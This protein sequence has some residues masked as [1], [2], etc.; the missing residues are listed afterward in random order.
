MTTREIA[1]LLYGA[2]AIQL[3]DVDGGEEGF[4]LKLHQKEPEAPLSPIYL[5]LRGAPKGS[6]PREVLCSIGELMAIRS[7]FYLDTRPF[8]AV[9]GLPKAGE[10]LAEAFVDW[11]RCYQIKPPV[12]LTMD[13]TEEEDSRRI[14]AFVFGDYR[15]GMVVVILDDLC[16]GA[17]TKLEATA[18][19]R[20]NGLLVRD[21]YVL[22]DR[23]QGGRE[24]LAAE[25]IELHSIFTLE[26]LLKIYESEK[27]ISSS[28]VQQVENYKRR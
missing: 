25:G 28:I 2:G 6:L 3:R 5:N 19:L 4:R 7:A 13:K 17:H 8:D 9:V 18:G 27:L 20:A 12:L 1:M 16:T 26:G 11:Y 23:E 15:P 10:P 21:C 14:E 22:V 24:Q